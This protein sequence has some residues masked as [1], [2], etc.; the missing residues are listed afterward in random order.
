M[1][2][3]FSDEVYLYDYIVNNYLHIEEN[4]D[5]NNNSKVLNNLT[6]CI[7]GKLKEYKNRDELIKFIENNGGKVVSTV[8]KNVNYL[9]NN[10]INSTSSKNKKAKEYGIPIISEV[11][12][13]QMI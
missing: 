4:K 11:E 12:L 6:F 5:N 10:D 8:S 9:I 1:L 3:A 7:T 2:Q 13:K